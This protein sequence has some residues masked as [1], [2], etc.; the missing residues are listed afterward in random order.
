ML[1]KN[2]LTSISES[3]NYKDKT[4]VVFLNTGDILEGKFLHS[5]LSDVKTLPGQAKKS[6]K[7]N[8]ILYSEIRPINKHF[9]LVKFEETNNCH[10][11]YVFD[12]SNSFYSMHVVVHLQFTKKIPKNVQC[13][14]IIIIDVIYMDKQM[15]FEEQHQTSHPK[16]S[17]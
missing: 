15:P 3:F 12:K 2:V 8:D 6:I 1:I 4:N 11:F 14:K 13:V 5:N 9:A 16:E 17:Q 7:H 10:G